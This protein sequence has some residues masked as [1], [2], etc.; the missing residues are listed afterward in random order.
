M[1]HYFITIST[2]VNSSSSL[3]SSKYRTIVPKLVTSHR[4]GNL[5]Q[6]FPN[7]FQNSIRLTC[8][9]ELCCYEST[10]QYPKH[11]FVK[12]TSLKSTFSF[13]ILFRCKSLIYKVFTE[14]HNSQ[15]TVLTK[16]KL[17]YGHG[18][19]AQ[20]NFVTDGFLA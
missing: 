20:G 17:F 19:V 18:L 3:L 5:W 1:L 14:Y 12:F 15:F 9:F 4:T 10:N 2:N 16:N 7:T 8:N 6:L 13:K 11:Y